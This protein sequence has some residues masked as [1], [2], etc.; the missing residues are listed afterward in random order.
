M[1]FNASSKYFNKKAL[2]T[3]ATCIVLAAGCTDEMIRYDNGDG[4]LRFDISLDSSWTKGGVTTRGAS[5]DICIEEIDA[6]EDGRQLYLISESEDLDTYPAATPCTRGT[7]TT[8]A[9]FPTT[10]GLSAICYNS[11]E[12]A[13]DLSSFTANFACNM[14]VKKSDGVFPGLDWPGSGRIRFLGYAPYASTANGITH[15]D[16][17]S[18][19]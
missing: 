10:F 3:V 6:T 8:E 11:S 18:V 9:T 19:V 15:S 12:P 1:I 2:A 5:T 14:E 16:R 17:K 7:S 13:S 4:R